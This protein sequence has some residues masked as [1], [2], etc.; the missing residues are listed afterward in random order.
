VQAFEHLN[1]YSVFGLAPAASAGTSPAGA[2]LP[3]SSG[4]S[5]DRAAVPWHPDSGVFWLAVLGVATALGIAGASV[6]VKAGPARA[7]ASVGKA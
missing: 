5:T 7:G 6:R 4:S 1:P 3:G 2:G